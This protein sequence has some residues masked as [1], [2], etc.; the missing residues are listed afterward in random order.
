MSER[1]RN[2][3]FKEKELFV[4]SVRSVK[5]VDI[6]TPNQQDIDPQKPEGN[7]SQNS[8]SQLIKITESQKSSFI[9]NQD[10]GIGVMLNDVSQK[11]KTDEFLHRMNQ[12]QVN[13]SS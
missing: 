12:Y 13:S 8:S 2:G 5:S 3:L 9:S 1:E 6:I 4:N 10:A 11:D 7:Q